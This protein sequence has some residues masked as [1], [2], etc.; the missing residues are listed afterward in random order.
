M[1]KL[2]VTQRPAWQALVAHYDN[3]KDVLMRD[4]FADDPIRGEQLIVQDSGL[5]MDYS[6]HRI[7]NETDRKHVQSILPDSLAGLTKVLSGLR[8]QEAVFVGQA[9]VLPSRILIRT[10]DENQRP[11]SHDI[12]FDKGWQTD[13]LLDEQLKKI[14]ERWRLQQR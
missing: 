12:D 5:Y 3:I 7:T 14:A 9:A 2:S 1:K 6:K 13:P 8:R 11:S 4:L 10:L